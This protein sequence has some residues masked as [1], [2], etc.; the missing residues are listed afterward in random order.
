[1]SIE[2]LPR[3]DLT[4]HPA[5]CDC[6]IHRIDIP[7]MA[8]AKLGAERQKLSR[9][10]EYTGEIDN[11]IFGRTSRSTWVRATDYDALSNSFASLSAQNEKQRV[12]LNKADSLIGEWIGILLADGMRLTAIDGEALRKK[13]ALLAQSRARECGY[14]SFR[15][16]TC[17]LPA[18]HVGEH[19]SRA[20][21]TGST[22]GTDSDDLPLAQSRGEQS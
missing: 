22:W 20:D 21:G 1:M 9:A 12:L 14:A 4:C 2:K 10:L 18:G 8:S 3:I 6:P 5:D 19:N 16:H 13:I 11:G 17:R 7:A 15:A